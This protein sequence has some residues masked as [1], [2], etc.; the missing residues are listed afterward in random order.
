[1]NELVN[2]DDEQNENCEECGKPVG[3]FAC[4]VR[5]ININSGSAKAARDVDKPN[6]GFKDIDGNKF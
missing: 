5:H 1:M 2:D 4:K 3:S 6:F